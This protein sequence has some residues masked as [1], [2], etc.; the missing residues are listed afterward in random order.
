MIAHVDMD[1][2]FVALERLKNPSLKGKPVAVGVDPEIGRSVVTSASYEAR[3]FG[4]GSAMPMAVAIRRC[5]ELIV[6]PTDFD[7]Y[8]HYHFKVKEIFQS[9]S[10]MVEMASIDEGYIDLSGTERLWGG[11]MEA[12]ER[13]RWT[14]KQM[15]QLDCTVGMARTKL[16]AKIASSEAKPNGLLWVPVETEAYFLAPFP[17]KMIP[18]VGAKKATL[19]K[20]FGLEQIGQIAAAGELLMESTLGA[21]GRW[22]WYASMGKYESKLL[23][24]WERKSISKE[25]TF[26]T[27]TTDPQYIT[28]VLHMLTEK[29][30]RRLRKEHKAARTVSVKLRYE[31]FNT[32]DRSRTL[33][34]PESRDFSLFSV[35]KELMFSAITRRVGI[36]LIGVGLSNLIGSGRQTNLFDEGEWIK[37]WDRLDAIDKARSR[38]GFNAVLVGEAIRLTEKR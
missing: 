25:M 35:A 11:P 26:R 31:D 21:T 37:E 27:D 29:V 33:S 9:F 24:E 19:L 16:T 32:I 34:Q 18:G 14:V 2:F 7:L 17:V 23:P 15:T 20:S 12:G 6:V 1:C 36:R 8:N 28:A 5:P 13:I 38:F 10:P 22:L 3:K 30:C 4:I